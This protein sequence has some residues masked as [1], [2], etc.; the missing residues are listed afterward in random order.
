MWLRIIG[1]I[2]LSRLA[3]SILFI[4]SID[5]VADCNIPKLR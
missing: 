5:R 2:M 1:F 4:F 3:V